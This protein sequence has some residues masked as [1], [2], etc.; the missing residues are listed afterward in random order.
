MCDIMAKKSGCPVGQRKVKGSCIPV[1]QKDIKASWCR[2]SF[3]G[4]GYPFDVKWDATR[5]G[6]GDWYKIKKGTPIIKTSERTYN[7][8]AKTLDSFPREILQKG[9]KAGVLEE[10]EYGR[11]KY[12]DVFIVTDGKKQLIIDSQGYDYPRYKSPVKIDGEVKPY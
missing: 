2:K 4:E 8:I 5:T 11:G 10:R 3:G 1:L 7:K 9:D 12:M 6:Y